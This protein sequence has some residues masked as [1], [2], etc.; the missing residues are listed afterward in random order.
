MILELILIVVVMAVSNSLGT[1]KTIFVSKKF[2]RPVYLIVFIDALIFAA[3]ISKVVTTGDGT[4]YILAFALGKTIGVFLGSI[5]ENK[6]AFGVL[7]VDIFF[8][9]KAKM[10]NTADELRG[11]GYSANTLIAYG[12]NGKKRYV[13]KATLPRKKLNDL[14]FTVSSNNN[15]EPTFL[16]KEVIDVQGKIKHSM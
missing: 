4:Y 12:F 11:K 14:K 1:L 7:E 16:I 3:V 8:N 5:V 10:V 13:V 6:L 9:N 2:L 15:K